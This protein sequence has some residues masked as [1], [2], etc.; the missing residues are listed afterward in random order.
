MIKLPGLFYVFNDY[1]EVFE[2][3]A[4]PHGLNHYASDSIGG[5]QPPDLM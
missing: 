4:A 1:K 2:S 5:A 3:H